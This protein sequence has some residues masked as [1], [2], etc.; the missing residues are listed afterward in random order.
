M[1]EWISV[2]DAKPR[3]RGFRNA[4]DAAARP[5]KG[6]PM[7]VQRIKEALADH[8]ELIVPVLAWAALTLGLI[9]LAVL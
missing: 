7:T 3:L 6:E 9:G 5:A 1:S 4:L 8:R 2:K